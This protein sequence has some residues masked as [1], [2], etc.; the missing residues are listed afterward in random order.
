MLV[1]DSL[2]YTFKEDLLLSS[3]RFFPATRLSALIA[4]AVLLP[5]L[6]HA[7]PFFGTGAGG[8]IPDG[9]G[10]GFSSTIAISDNDNITAF[11]NIVITGLNHTWIGDLVAT[12]THNG[13]TV[14]IFDRVGRTASTGAGSNGD[15][16]ATTAQAYTF[17]ASGGTT[18][19]T[20][21][22]VAP[23]TYN[24]FA[25]GTAGQSS[26]ATGTFSDFF[27]RS[28]AGVWTLSIADLVDTDTGSFASWGFN[29]T[30]APPPPPPFGTYT[31][32]A[33][34]PIAD[35]VTD[36][37]TF[38]TTPGV[39]NSDIT[40]ADNFVI[41]SLNSITVRGLTHTLI[42]DLTMQLIHVDTGTTVDLV[43]RLGITNEA[44][45]FDSGDTSNL[46]GDYTFALTGTNLL[47][48]A[49]GGNDSF[50]IPVGTYAASTSLDPNFARATT[51]SSFSG[52]NIGGTWRLRITDSAT[53][54]VGGFVGWGFAT[55]P[56]ATVVPEAGTLALFLPALAFGAVVIR[57]KRA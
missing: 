14:D 56:V 8:N 2:V 47:T 20:T 51:L 46:S 57:R 40:V 34:A 53:G 26:T 12:L 9:S 28:V 45:E 5:A 25:N 36:F 13:I 3:L 37:G 11:N 31:N 24:V 23:G 4:A 22:N 32:G 15:F 38:V 18:I 55:T 43:R 33:G 48:A 7:R 30:T 35:A 41:S 21:G 42:G 17:V 1:P 6:A 52:Q 16:T 27:G 39:T 50:N 49:Q 54:D 44:D 19:P 29:A 10:T